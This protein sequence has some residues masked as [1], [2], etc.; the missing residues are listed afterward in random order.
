MASLKSVLVNKREKGKRWQRREEKKVE[1]GQETGRSGGAAENFQ[2]RG[3]TG[4]APPQ[5][6]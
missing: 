4:L 1:E 5:I 6:L 2:N 3:E